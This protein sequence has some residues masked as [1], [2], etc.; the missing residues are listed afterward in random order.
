MR[1]LMCLRLRLFLCAAALFAPCLSAAQ[2]FSNGI[3]AVVNGRVITKSEVRDAVRAQEQ[4]LRFQF[5]PPPP[6]MQKAL[7]ELHATALD[8]MIDRELVLAEF[9]K[10]GARL[11]PRVVDDAINNIILDSFKGDRDAFVKELARTGMTLQKFRD[12]QE[13]MV[14]VQA[15]RGR[16]AADQPPATPKEVQ[17]FYKKHQ[18]RW[19]KGDMVKISTITIPKYTGDAAAPPEAQRKLA[20]DI[21]SRLVKG[22]DFATMAKTYSQDSRAE[23][24][25]AWDWM[26]TSQ[27]KN[28]I[29]E[30][31]FALDTGGIS[32]LVEEEGTYI[33]ISCDAKKYGA[34]PP[35][36]TVR[37][38]IEKMISQ[39]KSREAVEKWMEGLRRKAVIKR[40]SN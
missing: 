31:A 1:P 15:M 3:A 9:A 19:R 24:G 32:D 12:I 5:P 33:I 16:Y 13:K 29:A 34:V 26:E 21:R 27:M 8:S 30:V 7:D 37:S 40:V 10:L 28:S 22:A 35:L 23:D 18:A 4:L 6:A 39:E 17:D 11:P 38:D 14:I 2:S 20:L 36:D 25:G